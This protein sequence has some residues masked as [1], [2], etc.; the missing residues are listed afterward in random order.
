MVEQRYK[1]LF[2]LIHSRGTW[3]NEVPGSIDEE[4]Y[5][6]VCLCVHVVSMCDFLFSFSSSSH[7]KEKLVLALTLASTIPVVILSITYS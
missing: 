4:R 6:W 7:P 5:A 3:D 2:N 1:N